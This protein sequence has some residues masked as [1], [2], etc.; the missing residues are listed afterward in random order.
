MARLSHKREA[1][2]DEVEETSRKKSQKTQRNGKH[3]GGAE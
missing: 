3:G 2:E 1:M